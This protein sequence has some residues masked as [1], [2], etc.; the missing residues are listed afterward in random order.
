LP[1]RRLKAPVQ[2]EEAPQ[3][4]ALACNLF[5]GNSFFS[6]F[7]KT[8]PWGCGVS[9][10]APLLLTSKLVDSKTKSLPIDYIREYY[11]PVLVENR[12]V[13]LILSWFNYEWLH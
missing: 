4:S 5:F 1:A 9:E 7:I 6:P 8:H 11:L 13:I 10:L 3:S 12:I 2:A